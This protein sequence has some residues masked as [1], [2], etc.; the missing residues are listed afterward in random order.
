MNTIKLIAV[1]LDGTL[2]TNSKQLTERT[3]SAVANAL[4]AGI[5]VVPVTGRPMSGI[6]GE[7]LC[8]PGIRYVISSNGAVTEDL[9]AGEKLR[10]ALLDA[11]TAAAIAEIPMRLGLIHSV[12]IDGT[13]FCEPPFFEKQLERFRGTPVETYVR[14][15]RKITADLQ[16]LIRQTGYGVENIWIMAGDGAERDALDRMIRETWQV[17][18]V[19]TAAQD[20]EVGSPEADK[21]K[22][23][24]ALADRLGIRKEEIL[25]VGDNENDLGMFRA[26]GMA[27]AMGNAS[28]SVKQ[29]ACMVT[30][31]N[32]QDGAAK[33]IE[34]VIAEMRKLQDKTGTACMESVEKAAKI[35]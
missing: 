7:V 17:Q 11:D 19:L 4:D 18:T 1:D 9:T 30:D 16:T 6:P 33:V 27:A 12:F 5:C 3:R 14:R 31:T 22:A 2:L 13:G 34:T 28:D 29:A 25:A 10:S 15:S 24:A 26:A 23:L 21:G 20:I 8:I 32:E 35:Y